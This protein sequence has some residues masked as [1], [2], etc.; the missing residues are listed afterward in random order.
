MA[1]T[2]VYYYDNDWRTFENLH[3]D[4]GIT[5]T[6]STPTVV[7]DNSL[8]QY[9]GWIDN[10]TQDSN[11]WIINDSQW[12]SLNSIPYWIKLEEQDT[13]YLIDQTLD[14]DTYKKQSS[15]MYYYNGELQ[16]FEFMYNNFGITS[17]PSIVY[18]IKNGIIKCWYNSG[19]NKYWDVDTAKWYNEAPDYS[20]GGSGDIDS[21]GASGLF[22]Y[23]S[24]LGQPTPY[25]TLV[26]GSTLVPVS[27]NMPLSGD[28]SCQR[29][30]I[31]LTGTWKILTE[32]AE[33]S[34]IKPCIVFAT[35]VSDIS[36]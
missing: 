29:H 16:S 12:Y 17:T 32:V 24:S 27:I 9:S 20:G 7:Y 1:S 14:L 36:Q 30:S 18:Y 10:D 26:N 11:H 3:D 22:L 13:L 2:K 8:N 25:G 28:M 5:L 23:Y 33:T 4:Y 21:V 34:A 35:K 6:Q 15:K 19:V 31:I